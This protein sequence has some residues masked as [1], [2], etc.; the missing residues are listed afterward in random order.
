MRER[1]TSPKK[2]PV[3]RN[4]GVVT[5]VVIVAVAIFL[6]VTVVVGVFSSFST[7]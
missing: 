6:V 3:C 4:D 5:V 7:F 2:G 1:E